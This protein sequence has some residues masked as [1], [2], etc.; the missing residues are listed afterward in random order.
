MTD[1][2]KD[3]R[4]CAPRRCVARCLRPSSALDVGPYAVRSFHV[5]RPTL[6]H[7]GR[8]ADILDQ[9]CGE[10]GTRGELH[11]LRRGCLATDRRPRWIGSGC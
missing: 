11:A 5:S 6:K 4:P 8:F 3:L 10:R 9:G 2:P 7:R 1:R